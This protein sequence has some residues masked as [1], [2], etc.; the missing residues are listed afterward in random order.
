MG[1]Q[2]A[3]RYRSGRFI[4]A[5]FSVVGWLGLCVSLPLAVWAMATLKP[6]GVQGLFLVALALLAVLL[7]QIG[8]AVFDIAERGAGAAGAAGQRD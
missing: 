8:R 1:A 3:G 4:A 6:G 5:L 2:G 7:G